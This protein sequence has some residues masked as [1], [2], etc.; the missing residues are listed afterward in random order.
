MP[1]AVPP[2]AC[3][4]RHDFR[5]DRA[6]AIRCARCGIDPKRLLQAKASELLA[7]TGGDPVGA[8]QAAIGKATMGFLGKFMGGLKDEVAKRI[9][10]DPEPPPPSTEPEYIPPP[11]KGK[12]R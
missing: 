6:G 12:K 9:A 2:D 8:A 10:P 5:P 11:P 4:G 7:A 3:K 1:P